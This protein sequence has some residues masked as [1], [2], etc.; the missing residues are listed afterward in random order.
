MQARHPAAVAA[1]LTEDHIAHLADPE[2]TD[3]SPREQTAV[4]FAYQFATDHESISPAQVVALSDHF[5]YQEIVE[6]GMLCAQFVGFGRL[7][8]VLG[9]EMGMTC[10]LP[11]PVLATTAASGG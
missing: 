10:P 4:R 3:L 9:M 8:K 5:S 7:V 6:L 11:A 1:G 2:L